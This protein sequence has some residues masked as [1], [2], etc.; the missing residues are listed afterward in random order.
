MKEITRK[1]LVWEF[2]AGIG[3]PTFGTEYAKC[4]VKGKDTFNAKVRKDGKKFHFEV[5][6][7]IPD[8]GKVYLNGELGSTV[9]RRD[10]GHDT[11]AA[12]QNELIVRTNKYL[13]EMNDLEVLVKKFN[14]INQ[15]EKNEKNNCSS[16]DDYGVC[17]HSVRGNGYC[18]GA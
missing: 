13:N 4:Y 16:Y 5:V 11:F 2:H 10:F 12:V 8:N 9:G 18:I 6:Y 7:L 14:R 17:E 1:D 15:E 3:K